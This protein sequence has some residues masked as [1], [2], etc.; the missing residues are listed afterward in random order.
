MF[1]LVNSRAYASCMKLCH[2]Q[3]SCYNP[4]KHSFLAVVI[5]PVLFLFSLYILCTQRSNFDFN[6]CS[7]FTECCF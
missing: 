7:I 3:F 5:A 6:Q 4:I 2:Q 1:F